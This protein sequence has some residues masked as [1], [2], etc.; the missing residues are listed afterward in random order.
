TLSDRE[1]GILVGVD[2]SLPI[3]TVTRTTDRRH[4]DRRNWKGLRLVDRSGDLD[5]APAEA[6]GVAKQLPR[7]IHIT[8]RADRDARATNEGERM[9]VICAY[10]RHHDG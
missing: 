9:Q 8:T 1:A 6:V 10:L 3:G 7:H 5:L 2:Q 4:R